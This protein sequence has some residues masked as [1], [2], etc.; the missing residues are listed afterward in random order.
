MEQNN[1]SVLKKQMYQVAS[2]YYQSYIKEKSKIEAILDPKEREKVKIAADSFLKKYQFY[3][4]YYNRINSVKTIVEASNEEKIISNDIVSHNQQLRKMIEEYNNLKA[5][6][7]SVSVLNELAVKAHKIKDELMEL[8]G[9]AAL[10]KKY[11]PNKIEKFSTLSVPETVVQTVQTVLEEKE[12]KKVISQQS[13]TKTQTATV[14]RPNYSNNID[15]VALGAVNKRISTMKEEFYKLNP[16]SEEAKKMR[17]TLYDLALKREEIVTRCVGDSG[18][19]MLGKIE[20]MEDV[21]YSTTNFDV[22]KPRKI[23]GEQYEREL[24]HLLLQINDIQF[25]E[26][27]SELFRNSVKDSENPGE[28]KKYRDSLIRKYNDMI[29][30]VYG[31]DSSVLSMG[32]DLI[33]LFRTFNLE[34]GYLKFKDKHKTGMV[35]SEA[36]SRNMY[37][38]GIEEINSLISSLTKLSVMTIDKK[39][40]SVIISNQNKTRDDKVKEIEDKYYELY[41]AVNA[42]RQ[43][44]AKV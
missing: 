34:G 13:V 1:L 42:R 11:L 30:S 33:A 26:K 36:I 31:E 5:N 7:A 19:N 27:D 24:K 15:V 4:F 3:L 28:L 18:I 16:R 25:N 39:G 40:G 41:A 38:D 6:G 8:K 23:T 20:S 32:Q 2:Q 10:Y 35:G 22:P 21:T 43:V 12:K 9:I 14:K 44:V 29:K 17:K 37:N